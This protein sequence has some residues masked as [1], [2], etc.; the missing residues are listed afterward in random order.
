MFLLLTLF[1]RATGS[2]VSQSQK[3][4]QLQMQN[5]FITRLIELQ[6]ENTVT[7]FARYLE[8]PQNTLDC[9]IKG[10]RK[11]SVELVLRVCKKCGVSADW[12]LGLS[13]DRGGSQSVAPNPVV[14]KKR[15][16]AMNPNADLSF[17]L[18]AIRSELH[19]QAGELAALKQLN[20]PSAACCG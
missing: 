9:Y 10:R 8:L 2:S 16:S 7:A 17:E 19:R 12:L 11:P 4:C 6:G 15:Q 13:D 14:T 3:G 5:L 18:A 20:Q 1:Y